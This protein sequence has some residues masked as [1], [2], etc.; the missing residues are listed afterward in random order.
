MDLNIFLAFAVATAIMIALPGPNV[1]LT[2]AH[3]ISFGWKRALL[4]VAGATVGIVIQLIIAAIGL[5]SLLN[6]AAE[7]FACIRWVGAA[8]LVYLGIIQWRS[9]DSS[10]EFERPPVSPINLFSQGFW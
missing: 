5:I 1:I 3:S 8:Y 6:T 7:V 9:S 4:T 2:V 10:L